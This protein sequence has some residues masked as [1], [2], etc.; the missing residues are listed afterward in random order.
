MCQTLLV[1]SMSLSNCVTVVMM[2]PFVLEQFGVQ[3]QAVVPS[4]PRTELRQVPF[5]ISTPFVELLEVFLVRRRSCLV[6]RIVDK[7]VR[8]CNQVRI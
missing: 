3:S 4:S 6:L 8:K 7:Y 1:L 2:K 5:E